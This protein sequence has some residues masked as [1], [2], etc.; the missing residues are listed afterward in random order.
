MAVTMAHL[1]GT[2]EAVTTVQPMAVEWVQWS[3][4][5]MG[6]TTVESLAES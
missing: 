6:S 2:Y 5:M 3:A 4:E 1:S